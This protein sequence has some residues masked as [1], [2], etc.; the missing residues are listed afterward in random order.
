MIALPSRSGRT[1][2]S[3]SC[4]AQ[5]GDPLLE[6]V[7]GARRAG[8]ALRA[9]AGRAVG[10]GQLVQPGQQRPGVGD[11]AAHR[12]VGPLARRRSRGSA[13]AARPAGR[14]PWSSPCRTA[15][16][17]SRCAVSLAPT[18]SWWWKLTPPPASNRRVAGLPMSCSSAASRSTRSGPGTGRRPGPVLEVDR[19]LEHGE[20]VLVDVLVPVVLVDLQ[21]QRRAA[22]AARSSASPVSTSSSSPAPRVRRQEQLRP[23]RRGP[24]RR[25]R[26]RAVAASSRIAAT[27]SG[28][29]ARTRAGRRTGR[30][31]SSAA[32]RRR[33]TP[34]ACPG[35]A[36]VPATRSASP[37]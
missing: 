1:A 14:P 11:V 35:C 7:V 23:A 3:S 34:P 31:A 10:A 25:R 17:C 16:P 22:R 28:S 21:A 26:S 13:G 29:D 15:A 24:A 9:V 8:A 27:T 30:R 6:V 18:T 2:A 36:A 5:R 33:R 19:L 4:R 37:P 32:G 20:R 12:R